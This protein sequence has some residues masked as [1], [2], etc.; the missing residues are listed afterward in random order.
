MT[1]PKGPISLLGAG[2]HALVVAFAAREAGHE[3]LGAYD[4][5]QDASAFRGDTPLARLGPTNAFDGSTPWV[6]AIG[7]VHPRRALLRTLTVEHATSIVHPS[8]VIAPDAHIGRG[9]FIG[10]HAVVHPRARIHD[11]AIINTRAVIEHEC[12]VGENTHVSPGSVL[13]GN[14]KVG[15]HTLIGAGSTVIPGVTIG[16]GCVVGAGSVVLRDIPPGVTAVGSPAK[17]LTTHN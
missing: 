16:E 15:A 3:P 8:A 4:D 11:H 14:V 10:P 5:D 7:S 9:V 13:C 2:G 1:D 12:V 17:V 6:L